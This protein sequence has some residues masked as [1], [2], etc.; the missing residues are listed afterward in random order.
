MSAYRAPNP[1]DQA[2]RFQNRVD[3]TFSVIFPRTAFTPY[4]FAKRHEIGQSEAVTPE[5][6]YA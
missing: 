1:V 5:T 3:E 6:G 4:D 2:G